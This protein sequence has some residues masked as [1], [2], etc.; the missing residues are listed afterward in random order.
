MNFDLDDLSFAEQM[1]R[2]VS[3]FKFDLK[4]QLSPSII[5]EKIKDII[6]ILAKRGKENINLRVLRGE[7]SHTFN[8]KLSYI[9]EDLVIRILD[10]LGFTLQKVGEHLG[11]RVCWV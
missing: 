11:H 5:K 6:S 3:N 10:E 8:V 1:K 7:L 4:M 9:K 2:E